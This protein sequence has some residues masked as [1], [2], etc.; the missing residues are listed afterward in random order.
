MAGLCGQGSGAGVLVGSHAARHCQTSTF[1]TMAFNKK[2]QSIEPA[3][4]KIRVALTSRDVKSLETG[5]LRV[6][7]GCMI[8]WRS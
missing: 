7:R 6:P 3:L 4:H 2:Q 5:E 1:D 8:V